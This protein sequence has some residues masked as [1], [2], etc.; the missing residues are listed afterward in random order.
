MITAI[1]FEALGEHN[2][3]VIRRPSL[4]F[5]MQGCQ[6]SDRICNLVFLGTISMQLDSS[7]RGD[8]SVFPSLCLCVIGVL[9]TPFTQVSTSQP[10]LIEYPCVALF[11]LSVLLRLR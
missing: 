10:K 3:A 5:F 9:V 1:M 2:P 4:F 11:T 8:H 6:T 7:F